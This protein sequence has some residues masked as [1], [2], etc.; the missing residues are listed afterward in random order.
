MLDF[1]LSDEQKMLRRM[2]HDF[3]E[4]EIVPVAAHYDE[5]E[6]FPYDLIEKARQVGLMNA[7]IPEE[8]GGLGA[9]VLEECILGEEI[10]WG[11]SGIGTVLGINALAAIPIHVGGTVTQKKKWFGLLMDGGLGAYAVTEPNAGSDV[12]GM[13]TSAVKKGDEYVLNGSKTFISNASHADFVVVFARTNKEDRYGGVSA[14]IVETDR[15][16]F[17][18][19]KKFEK[20]GQRAADTAEISMQDVVIPKE[21]L[22]GGEGAGFLIA[23]RVFDTSRPSVAA[24]AIGVARR[25][26]EEALK[27][28]KEREAFGKPIYKRQAVGHKLADMAMNIE[29][30]RMLAW[31]AAWM[32]D[33]N[34]N[35]S[36]HAAYA[37]AFCAD[38][39]M[40]ACVDAVQVLGGYGYM[41]EYPVE[42]LMR[43]VKVYQIYE[44]TSEIQRNIIVREMARGDQFPAV[45]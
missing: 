28:S 20:L 42:K 32:L 33:N 6:E 15:E 35:N 24:A 36:L 3:A 45:M 10:N 43:D 16:G 18:V 37:K 23:M 8:Y 7:S 38:A 30:G 17:S 5:T 34:K 12:A 39:A 31:Q 13:Q 26:M 25:A 11:C 21:N 40:Q 4:Q 41:R 2:A 19:S 1:T 44:G 27:Y 22:L 14:F 29:A 9:T